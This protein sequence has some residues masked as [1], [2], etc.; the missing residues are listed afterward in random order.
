[1]HLEVELES[2]TGLQGSLGIADKHH[3]AKL[4]I[5]GCPQTPDPCVSA[6]I[7]ELHMCAIEPSLTSGFLFFFSLLCLPMRFACEIP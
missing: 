1:M 3:H 5:P 2:D 4:C 7:L 6:W